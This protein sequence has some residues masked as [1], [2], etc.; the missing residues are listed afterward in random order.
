M[1]FDS[2]A[3]ALIELEAMKLSQTSRIALTALFST[4]SGHIF[5]VLFGDFDYLLFA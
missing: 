1:E 3:P 2:K 4:Q 5:L